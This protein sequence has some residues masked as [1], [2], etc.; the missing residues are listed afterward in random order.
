MG[1]VECS[2]CDKS[3][4]IQ[5]W[6]EGASSVYCSQE[7]ANKNTKEA[8][9]LKQLQDAVMALEPFAGAFADDEN[10]QCSYCDGVNEG[11]YIDCPVTELREVLKEQ[12]LTNS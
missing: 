9:Q 6:P 3:L 10:W 1:K 7:C 11:H 4:G 8:K 2:Q 12:G 5:E